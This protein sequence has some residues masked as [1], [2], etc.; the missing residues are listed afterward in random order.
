MAYNTTVVTHN[1]QFDLW[2]LN[3]EIDLCREVNPFTR[4]EGQPALLGTFCTLTYARGR[5]P[6]KK[7]D[8]NAVCERLGIDTSNRR[9]HGA[10]L[11]A[12]LLVEAY[13]KMQRG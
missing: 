8:L 5:W 3:N 2:F 11:D 6:R 7:N 1:A 9:L 10:L 13:L 4:Y 12:E